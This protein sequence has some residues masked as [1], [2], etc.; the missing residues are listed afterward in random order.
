VI[1]LPAD[2]CAGAGW[3]QAPVFAPEPVVDGAL[4]PFPAGDPLALAREMGRVLRS[5]RDAAEPTADGWSLVGARMEE[6]Y[7]GL[8]ASRRR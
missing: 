6:L 8:L 2:S 1:V 3:A 4:R 7:R 5:R